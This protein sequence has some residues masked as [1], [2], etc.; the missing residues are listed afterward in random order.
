MA[1]QKLSKIHPDWFNAALSKLHRLEL[2][3]KSYAIDEEDVP[4]C[5]E[6]FARAKTLLKSFA[7]EQLDLS[8]PYITVSLNGNVS[9]RWTFEHGRL[10]VELGNTGADVLMCRGSIN[11]QKIVIEG[12]KSVETLF[13]QLAS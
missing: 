4:P 7:D 1:L 9:M 6:V 2:K 8:E 12:T 5:R 3:A 10:D 13:K 11:G